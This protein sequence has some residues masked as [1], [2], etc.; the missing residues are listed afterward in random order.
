MGDAWER[1]LRHRRGRQSVLSAAG[2]PASTRLADDARAAKTCTQRECR[3][4]AM[5]R[6]CEPHQLVSRLRQC[7]DS[8]QSSVS[9]GSSRRR[10][11]G[12]DR[13]GSEWHRFA[14]R[15]TTIHEHQQSPNPSPLQRRTARSM[16]RPLPVA[17]LR[18]KG[19]ASARWLGSQLLLA[20]CITF[21]R[22]FALRKLC[23][24][25]SLPLLLASLLVLFVCLAASLTLNSP[26]VFLLFQYARPY[27]TSTTLV[28]SV[29]SRAHSSV[30]GPL[31]NW[32]A[33]LR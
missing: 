30:R 15:G 24:E 27:L 17:S 3:N 32:L 16:P 14:E 23:A 33:I 28:F 19:N 29:C 18:G 10:V 8:S 1:R 6:D 7:T 12:T 13:T 31:S 25:S 20:H 21:V 9:K 26:L 11:C 2:W 22:S 5:R 4:L